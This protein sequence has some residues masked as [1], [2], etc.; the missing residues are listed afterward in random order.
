M[1]MRCILESVMACQL[2]TFLRLLPFHYLFKRNQKGKYLK[3]LFFSP[4]FQK[5]FLISESNDMNGR[6]DF[7]DAGPTN[8]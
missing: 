2:H 8:L 1:M 3:H 7:S 5:K 6:G 4:G